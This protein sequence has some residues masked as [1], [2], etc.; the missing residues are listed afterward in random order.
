MVYYEHLRV[1]HASSFISRHL[2]KLNRP[3]LPFLS[4]SFRLIV[5][6]QPIQ[7]SQWAKMVSAEMLI[8]IIS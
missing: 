8:I 5:P 6:L 1:N 2:T 4:L 3:F 7:H